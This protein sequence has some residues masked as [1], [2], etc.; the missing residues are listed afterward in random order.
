MEKKRRKSL[1]DQLERD[2]ALEEEEKKK[3]KAA[4]K[5]REEQQLQEERDKLEAEREQRS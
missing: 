4:Q 5:V 3:R 2:K 1:E